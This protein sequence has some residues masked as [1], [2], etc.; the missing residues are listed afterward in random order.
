MHDRQQ[1]TELYGEWWDAI[2]SLKKGDHYILVMID[3]AG[4]PPISANLRIDD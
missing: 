2:R 4:L 1:S 3:G